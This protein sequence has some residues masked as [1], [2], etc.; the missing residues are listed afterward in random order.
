MGPKPYQMAFTAELDEA[1]AIANSVE[2]AIDEAIQKLSA[3]RDNQNLKK[4][5]SLISS[6][7]DSLS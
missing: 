5:F 1:K 4:T 3:L 7:E 6:M 2:K